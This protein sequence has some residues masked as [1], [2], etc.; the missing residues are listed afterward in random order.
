MRWGAPGRWLILASTLAVIV[1]ATLGALARAQDDAP[2]GMC[3]LTLDEVG[4]LTDLTFT[5]AL[6]QPTGCTY[7]SDPA[8][9][10]YAL[11]LRILPESDIE[12]V[13]YTFVRDGMETTVAGMP[14]WSSADGLFIDVGE[15]LLA[16]QPIFFFAEDAPDPVAVQIPIAEL[17]VP[18]V[19][20]AIESA[21]GATDRLA[22]AFPT[23]VAGIPIFSDVLN[24]AEVAAYI[25][26]GTAG[27]EEALAGIGLTLADVSIGM[28]YGNEPAQ[29]VAL[30]VPGADAS[31]IVPAVSA[32]F[33]GPDAV[34]EPQVRGGR[35][36]LAYPDARLW[37]YVDGD[38]L[39]IV[40]NA[41]DAT[42]DAFFAALP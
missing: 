1:G 14:A 22:A 15:R 35:E 4:A 19:G 3:L 25:D 17:A 5:N 18:R 33:A 29:L 12:A 2:V 8:G 6:E 31:I 39:W 9:E 27:I 41:D 13:R 36:V 26:L 37:L 38:I 11:D 24:L 16:I 42:I 23:E 10:M 34:A 40:L 20:S 7:Q 21:F 28:A 30:Q 32:R